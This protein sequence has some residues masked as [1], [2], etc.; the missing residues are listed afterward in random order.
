MSVS[1]VVHTRTRRH[2]VCVWLHV[3]AVERLQPAL[4]LVRVRRHQER[5]PP[6]RHDLDAR[7]AHVQ[8]VESAVPDD[9]LMFVTGSGVTTCPCTYVCLLNLAA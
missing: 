2:V 3:T 7:R 4:E 9:V 5:A 8:Q 6:A 1:A